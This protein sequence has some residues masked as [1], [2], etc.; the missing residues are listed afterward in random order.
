[1]IISSNVIGS[2]IKATDKAIPEVGD[3]ELTIPQALS[4]THIPL[5]PHDV[6]T[7]TLA[8]QNGS[9]LS[10]QRKAVGPSTVGGSQSFAWIA[11]GLWT[12]DFHASGFGDFISTI[13]PNWKVE[14]VYQTYTIPLLV[15]TLANF[16]FDRNVSRR[17]L[18]RDVANI[19]ITWGATAAAQ[20]TDM[21][22]SMVATRHL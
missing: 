6:L 20:N 14:L 9:F 3:N 11:A 16:Y 19:Q 5:L 4:L 2:L 17:L 15:M 12:L 18:L 21:T 7:S 22:L 10:S 1:M 8:T 13:G